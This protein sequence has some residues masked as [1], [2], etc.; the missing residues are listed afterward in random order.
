MPAARLRCVHD[1]RVVQGDKD[2]GHRKGRACPQSGT[3]P[4]GPSYA[5]GTSP[6]VGSWQ[7]QLMG[8]VAASTGCSRTSVPDGFITAPPLHDQLRI[9]C[10]PGSALR[11]NATSG[12]RHFCDGSAT[13]DHQTDG[14]R[15]EVDCTSSDSCE[16]EGVKREGCRRAVEGPVR[17][18][19]EYRTTRRSSGS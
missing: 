16:A 12:Q 5:H 9:W 14:S 19:T 15:H 6:E 8:T 7:R 1:V 2:R 11:S 4:P 17:D 13:A 3:V 18:G 10:E